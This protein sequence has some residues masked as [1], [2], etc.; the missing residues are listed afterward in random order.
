MSLA[1]VSADAGDAGKVVARV[2]ANAVLRILR[3]RDT[4]SAFDD[5]L[6]RRARSPT[7]LPAVEDLT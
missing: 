4:A 5:P 3:R 7:R 1:A 6:R 2:A